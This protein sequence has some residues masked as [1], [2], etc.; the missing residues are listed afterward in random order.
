[1]MDRSDRHFRRLM[2]LISRRT[3]LYTEMITCPAILHGDRDHL[4]GYHADEHPLALQLG[5]DDPD[6]L[7]RC[8]AIA[9]ARGYD[10]INLNVGCP[11]DRVQS[12]NF[13]VCL[14]RT[15]ELVAAC[16]A[17]MRAAVPAPVTVKHR[18]GVDELDRY[19]DM[20]RFV[21]IVAEAGCD[22]FT[23]HARKAWLR[24][25]SPKQNRTVPPLRYADVHR[26]ARARPDL[27]VEINGGLRSLDAILEQLEH[28]DA[29]MIGRA[30]WDDP[31]LFAS[32]DRD[33]FGDRSREPPSRPEVVADYL[34]HVRE[35]LGAS[36][37]PGATRRGRGPSP[38][39]LLRPLMNLFTGRPGARRWKQALNAKCQDPTALDELHALA[40]ELDD[41]GR[42]R[43]RERSG[44]L[45]VAALDVG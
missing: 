10:E 25:L 45:G 31:W 1:M 5:G 6:A 30:A 33:V 19:E 41:L 23:I 22:R 3:L 32:V 14:M 16:V 13:G 7:A 11:S 27:G 17:A 39:I 18:I 44:S 37:E 40:L 29:A 20:A 15:P 28:V 36:P 35:W 8:A 43:D 4:L 38:T 24:G 42:E 21:E 34:E 12:G 2:R 26:L 9:V